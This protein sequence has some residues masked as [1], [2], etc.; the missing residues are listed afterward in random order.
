MLINM[1]AN[2]LTDLHYT[3][4]CIYNSNFA[5]KSHKHLLF[6]CSVWEED[7]KHP[8]DSGTSGSTAVVPRFTKWKLMF[9]IL[10]PS[11]IAECSKRRQKCFV[12]QLFLEPVNALH[13]QQQSSSFA[14][15]LL[16]LQ[17]EKSLNPSLILFA[18]FLLMNTL[19][20]IYNLF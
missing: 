19:Y 12:L 6:P 16:L 13:L 1:H 2:M 4:L 8:A 5:S 9:L 18:F 17:G 3:C 15:S 11:V 14:G 10:V 7:R 20:K